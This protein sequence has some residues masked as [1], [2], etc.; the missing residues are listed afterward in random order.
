MKAEAGNHCSI[1]YVGWGYFEVP[2][3]IYFRK[4]TGI[5]EPVTIN[6]MLSFDGNGKWRDVT[7]KI[8][9]KKLKT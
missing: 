4:G 7:I 2:M 9:A 5:K 6:H 3:T 8:N 1:T